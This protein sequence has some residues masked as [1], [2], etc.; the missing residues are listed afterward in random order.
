MRYT[1]AQDDETVNTTAVVADNDAPFVV[2]D[3][4]AT[5]T[6]DNSNNTDSK[7]SS[8]LDAFNEY[9]N[10]NNDTS[11]GIEE[12]EEEDIEDIKT[13]DDANATLLEELDDRTTNNVFKLNN[14]NCI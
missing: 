3:A 14:L 10:P 13:F 8:L 1:H 6:L 11:A 12:E 4:T 5:F 2:D 7:A 9:T